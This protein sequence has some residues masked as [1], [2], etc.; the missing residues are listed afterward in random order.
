[1]TK[2]EFY[3]LVMV[4]GAFAVFGVSMAIAYVQYRR[5]LKHQPTSAD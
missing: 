3:Y 5:W 2:G 1:M 4:C